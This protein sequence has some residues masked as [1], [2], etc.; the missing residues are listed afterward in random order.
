MSGEARGMQVQPHILKNL[1]GVSPPCILI[2][3]AKH[4]T[5]NL[6]IRN[7]FLEPVTSF[8]HRN[9]TVFVKMELVSEAPFDEFISLLSLM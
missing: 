8:I 6:R 5:P 3:V 1:E 9:F 4:R 2:T 7:L